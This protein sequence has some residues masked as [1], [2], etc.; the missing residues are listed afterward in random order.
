[1]LER[2]NSLESFVFEY[3]EVAFVQVVDEFSS[4]VQNSAV[5][6]DFFS[7]DVQRVRAGG[8]WF[9]LLSLYGR[10]RLLREWAPVS[11]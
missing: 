3:L 11:S 10:C 1:V 6:D 7:V 4:L 5:Q 8:A 2:D 9:G